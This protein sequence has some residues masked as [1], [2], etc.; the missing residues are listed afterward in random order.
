ML[1]SLLESQ[2]SAV[3]VTGGAAALEALG[4]ERFDLLIADIRMPGMNGFMLITEAR[5]ICPRLPV[6][7]ISAYYDE[8]DG[9]S[10]R[11]VG[12]YA[13]VALTKPLELGAVNDAVNVA[14]GLGS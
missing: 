11:V 7:I 6:V 9:V 8:N 13:Q 1:C 2:H 12:H 10:Q 3:G 5:R 4:R 14:L